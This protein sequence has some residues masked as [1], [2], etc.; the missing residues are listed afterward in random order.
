MR[1][2]RVLKRVPLGM[3]ALPCILALVHCSDEGGPAPVDTASGATSAAASSSA[4]AGSS[5]SSSSGGAMTVPPDLDANLTWYGDNRERL[6]ALIV[7]HGVRRPGYDPAHKPVAVFDWDN[8][9]I[10]NDVGDAT[11]FWM[12]LHDKILQPPQKNWALSSP[13]LTSVALSSLDAACGAL[14]Q[15]G[16]PLP[17]SANQGCADEIL[18]VYAA[19]ATTTK[20][21]AF[22]SYNH[23]TI[24]PAYAWAA[25]LLAG[26]TSDEIGELADQA[27]SA[28][29]D[30]AEGAEL[31][32]GSTSG[33]VGYIRIYDQMRDLISTLQQNGFDV[34][35]VSASPEVVV[36]R[37]AAKVN[38]NADHVIGIRPVIDQG[39]LTSNLQGCGSAPDGTNDGA[40][41]FTGNSLIPYIQGKRCWINK[42]IFGDTGPTALDKRPD[43]KRQAFA[44]GDSDTDITFVQDATTMKLVLNRN[45]P[46]LMCNAYRNHGGRWLINPMFIKPKAQLLAGYP[47]ST[48]GCVDEGGAKIPCLDEASNP[49]PDQADNVY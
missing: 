5:A 12:L 10:K 7:E 4:S 29:L 25:Q 6:N 41:K 22:A 18:S 21:P 34:W 20:Q 38:I 3:L 28:N 13:Y 1:A 8:T 42:V 14:A 32:V 35:V 15:P 19:G 17:T 37:A 48:T 16:E 46:E 26:Y 11:L 43:D 2:A 47:C 45:K 31:T 39:K 9:V 24:E 33:L 36:Q 40:G 44:A 49:I 23:R 27:I 30:A